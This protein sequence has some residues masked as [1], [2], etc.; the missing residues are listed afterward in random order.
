VD[1]GCGEGRVSRDLAAKAHTVTG[2]DAAPTMIAAA[3]EADPK[4]TYLQGDA[5]TC[6]SRTA[7]STWPSP[8][9][10]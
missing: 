10:R 2:V 3:R 7:V 4:G 6:R 8:T 5:A 9:T 1:I